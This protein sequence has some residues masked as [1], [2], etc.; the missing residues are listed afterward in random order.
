MRAFIMDIIRTRI[1]K[2]NIAATLILSILLITA[3]VSIAYAGAHAAFYFSIPYDTSITVL[4]NL[5]KVK[6]NIQHLLTQSKP[7]EK[8]E[9][10]KVLREDTYNDSA[11]LIYTENC[12]RLVNYADGYSIDFTTDSSFDFDYAPLYTRVKFPE[13]QIIISAER[14]PYADVDEYIRYYLNRFI[15]NGDYQKGNS[16]QVLEDSTRMIGEHEVRVISVQLNNSGEAEYN[17]YRFAT[18]KT[19]T[20]DFYRFLIKYRSTN[21]KFAAQSDE[22]LATFNY[23]GRE[24]NARYNVNFHPELP[25]NWSIETR[26]AYDT[27]TNGNQLRWGIFAEDIYGKGIDVT[28]PEIEQKIDY[29]F[30]LTLAY[31]HFGAEFPLEFMRKNYDNGKTVELTYQITSSNN[32][33]LMGYTPNL[34]IYRGIKDEE[35][36]KFARGAKEFG[37]PFLFRLNNEMNSDWTSYSGIVNLSDAD[38]YISNWQRVYRIFA[39]E[40]VNNAIWIFNPNDR[41]FPPCKWNNHVAYYPGNEYVQMLGVTGYNTGTYYKQENMEEWREFEAIYDEV[42]ESYSPFYS[43]FP[44]IIT[45]FASSSIG[46]NKVKWINNMFSV[47]PKYPLIKIAVWFS[48]ADYDPRPGKEGVVSRPYWLDETPRTLEAF[49]KGVR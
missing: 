36:R 14:S 13:A 40:G 10:G 17:M 22:F 7:D 43:E 41:N 44:W 11:K 33:N 9:F 28:I 2:R 26:A 4:S 24:N 35:I 1:K 45:E 18:I 19:S 39:E 31:L 46:G 15:T 3:S 32:E 30:D 37:H 6:N 21:S 8:L 42:V 27:I 5:S 20:R 23:F 25:D 34:D 47:M 29:K 49:G 48:S 12:T 38:I 16:I